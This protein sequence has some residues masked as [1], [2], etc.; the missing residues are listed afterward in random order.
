MIAVDTNLLVYAHRSAVK[1]HMAAR[2]ALSRAASSATGW[3]IPYP[4]VAEFLAVVTHPSAAG[5]PSTPEEAAR[6]L[7][8]LRD[9]G[10]QIL[11]PTHG[12]GFRLLR[13]AAE[14]GVRGVRIFDFQ[15][16][17]IAL[18]SDAKAIWT[19]DHD[20]CAPDGLSVHDPL[21]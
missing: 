18:E 16:G 20:F 9:A 3:G 2:S 7:E 13:Q 15:I 19:H 17:C 5:R 10:M 8:A 14:T 6:F 12:F 1:E 11:Y 4:C 21:V